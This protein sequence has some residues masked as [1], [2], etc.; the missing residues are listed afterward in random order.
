MKWKIWFLSWAIFQGICIGKAQLASEIYQFPKI[1]SHLTLPISISVK[2]INNLI[3][4]SVK[5]TIYEDNSYTD[6]DND[7]FRVKVDKY[8]EI[9]LTAL[10]DNRFLIEVPL[11]IWAEK[12][13]GGLGK[14]VYQDT[15]FTIVMKFITAVDFKTDWTLSTKTQTYGFEW[16]SKPVLDYGKV[17]IPIASLIESTLKEQQ[18]KFTTII[19][20]KIKE[21][22]DLKPYLLMVWNNFNTPI[23]ISSEY[24]TW[25]KITPET[26]YMTPIKIYADY[27]KGTVGVDLYSETYIG[28]IP[29]PNPLLVKFPDYKLRQDLPSEFLLKTTA[30]ISFAKA[31]ELAKEQFIGYEFA[32]TGEKKDVR[33]TDIRI[34]PQDKS[35][36][37]EIDTEGEVNGTSIIKGFPYYD[38]EKQRIALSDVDFK[39]KTKNFFQ[40]TLVF[41]FEGKIKRMIEKDY[42]IPMKDIINQSKQSL[43]ENFN[44]EYYPGIF[45]KGNVI[46]FK[47]VQVLLFGQFMTVVIDTRAK[48]K[49]EVDGLSF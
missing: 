42:G 33:V 28:Q 6:N 1:K 22:F 13:Y 41:L 24:K 39:L 17:K 23:N 40:K 19:D 31:D 29:M 25:L 48:L 18:A 3:N 34:Y 35:I 21:S 38:A 7:Q 46:D 30:N 37:L 15:N 44:K 16:G 27:I 49:M 12:G 32:L 20:Q 45:L 14:Y 36:V 5:G 11:K 4:N 8:G 10:K 43:H 47:P 26:V 2:E 9:K